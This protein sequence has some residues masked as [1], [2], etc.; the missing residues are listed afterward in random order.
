MRA[1]G[2]CIKLAHIS[3][4][5]YFKKSL[6][7]HPDEPPRL[8]K[9][10]YNDAEYQLLFELILNIDHYLLILIESVVYFLLKQIDL[11]DLL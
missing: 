4:E 11:V 2:K 5:K 3:L 1:Y 10:K 9:N 7:R 8:Y 6:P